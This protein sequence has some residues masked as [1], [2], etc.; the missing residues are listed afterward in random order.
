MIDGLT[1]AGTETQLLALIRSLDRRRF[2]PSL[3][4]LN[5]ENDLSREL[6][7]TDCPVL[8]LGVHSLCS[9][10]AMHAGAK[11]GRLWRRERVD[12]VQT[13]FLDST[14]FGVPLARLNGVRRVVRVRNNLSHW[15]TPRH[16]ALGR[17]MGRLVDVT[18]TNCEPARDALLQAEG[19]PASK[20]V[21]LENGVDLQRFTAV[22]PPR[23]PPTRIGTVA[24][25][26]PV[27]GIDVLIR[28]AAQLIRRFPDLEF[29]IAGEGEERARLER[30]VH[31]LAL[32]ER[33]FLPGT[34]ADVPA[35]LSRLDLVVA[36]SH[37]EG[38]SNALLEAMAAGRPI[39]AT[40]VGANRR[41]LRDG[42]L[43]V[44]APP[45]DA[46]ALA[47]GVAQLLRDPPHA[48]RLA[49]AARQ[50]VADQYSREAMRQRFERFYERLCA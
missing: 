33:F 14:Y 9:R 15:L 34:V 18:L 13:Y 27:K 3:V 43:G 47:A 31:E 21:V 10:Q 39:V 42:Q 38:M 17:L 4:L 45:G 20:V 29:H 7:P 25:L 24:N 11:L 50:H 41:L 19:G 44:M 8:R 35:F 48:L 16:R 36:P 23:E 37:A 2:E 26:R 30:L 5:G 12:I 1:R 46:P 32:H 49:A 40:D 22:A 6:E 28:A